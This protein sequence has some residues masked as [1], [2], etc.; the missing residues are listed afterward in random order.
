MVALISDRTNEIPSCRQ[1][2]KKKT[3]QNKKMVCRKRKTRTAA[4]G[5]ITHTKYAII[6]IINNY[7]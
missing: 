7:K 5:K 2:H 6:L 3:K 4:D 1:R